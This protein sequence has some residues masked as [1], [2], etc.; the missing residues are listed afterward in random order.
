MKD[1]TRCAVAFMFLLVAASCGGGGGGLGPPQLVTQPQ[2]ISVPAGLQASFNVTATGSGNL[3]YQWTR[4]GSPIAGATSATYSLAAVGSND[5]GASFAVTISNS[6]GSVMSLSAILTVTAAV[7]QSIEISPDPVSTGVNI[8][9]QLIA[10][11][12]FSDTSRVTLTTS[13]SWASA[14]PA[15]AA[16]NSASGLVTG[17][18]LGSTGIT[19]TSGAIVGSAQV[20][21]TTNTWATAGNSRV[22]SSSV[23]GQAAVLL[24]SGS[25]LLTGGGGGLNAYKYCDLYDPITNTWSATGDLANGRW[26]HTAILLQNGKVLVAGGFVPFNGSIT[27]TELYDPASGLWSAAASLLTARGDHQATL[28]A[29][30]RVL[31]TGGVT[32]VGDSAGAELYDP[33]SNTWTAIANFPTMFFSYTATLLPSGEIL[34]VGGTGPA[35]TVAAWLYDPGSLT[36]SAAA[37]PAIAHSSALLLPNG[38]VF[39]T[40]AGTPNA[41]LY[42][43]ASDAWLVAANPTNARGS[44]A[45]S[46]LLASGMVLAVGGSGIA[47]GGVP[48]STA[49]LYDP[50]SNS[51]SMAA[52]SSN[53]HAWQTATLLPNGEVLV[54][55]GNTSA[56]EVYW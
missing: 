54:A 10:I 41:E 42:D 5:N 1:I 12:I 3:T 4:N 15:V 53:A 36:W 29:D 48:T 2:G 27:S 23:S 44:D 45:S 24:S 55:G 37:S 49:E 6:V 14:V 9:R 43:P 13:V 47:P 56:A 20:S 17:I 30:G 38:K 26:G 46:T 28:L 18:S 25:V 7:L 11:G 22:G 52:N 8:S 33:A 19:V 50:G 21:V 31:V 51:W 35:K 40:G 39:A 32:P 34:L 16:V